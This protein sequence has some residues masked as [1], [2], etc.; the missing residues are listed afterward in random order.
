MNDIVKEVLWSH[1]RAND[2]ILSEVRREQ[3]RIKLSLETTMNT[4]SRLEAENDAIRD[5]L[6]LSTQHDIK[7]VSHE[8]H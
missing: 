8:D 4:I 3:N 7:D 6:E 2:G 1:L 5:V